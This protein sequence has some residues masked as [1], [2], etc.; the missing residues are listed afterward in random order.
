M[1]IIID[2]SSVVVVA[3]VSIAEDSLISMSDALLLYLLNN[4]DIVIIEAF[5]RSDCKINIF[6]YGEC[7]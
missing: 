4:M 1:G 2:D 6:S 5:N 3:D 7:V